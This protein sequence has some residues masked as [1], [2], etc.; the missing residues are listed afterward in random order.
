MVARF[1]AHAWID[2]LARALLVAADL[3]ENETLSRPLEERYAGWSGPL[4]RAIL[5]GTES[6]ASLEEKVASGAID[7]RPVSGRQEELENRVNR[8]IWS[9]DR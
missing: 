5:D 9:A 8:R 3:L 1:A 7:P 2:T 6:L 4:G